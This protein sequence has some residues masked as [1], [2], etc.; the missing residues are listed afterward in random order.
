MATVGEI[1]F[2][3]AELVAVLLPWWPTFR[4]VAATG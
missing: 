4:I 1:A 2:N 3:Q